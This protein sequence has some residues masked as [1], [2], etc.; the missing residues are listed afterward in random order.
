MFASSL[1]T[2]IEFL[3]GVGPKRAELLQKELG[4]FTYEQLLNYFPFRYIDRTRFYKINELSAELPYVQ[5]LGRITAKEQ[6]GEKHKKRI[7][8]KL[9]DETGV[10]ELVWFQSFMLVLVKSFL[11][12]SLRI[13]EHRVESC[14]H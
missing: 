1:A 2:T 10:I 3:K 6:I 4:I 5:V 11:L 7:V 13:L 14:S 12:F 9:T 8:A